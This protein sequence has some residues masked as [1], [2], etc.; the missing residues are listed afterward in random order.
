MIIHSGLHYISMYA[1]GDL[2]YMWEVDHSINVVL[3]ISNK[4]ILIFRFKIRSYLSMSLKYIQS[5]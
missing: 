4:F 5:V 3:E 2:V 1:D